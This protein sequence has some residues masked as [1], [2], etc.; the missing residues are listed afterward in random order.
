MYSSEKIKLINDWLG[1]GSINI[2]GRPFS[3]KDCQSRIL[4]DLL[5]GNM[6]G[7]GEI[8][9]GD[10]MPESVKQCMLLGTLVDTN[11][12]TE[13]ILHRLSQP[14][15][16][17]KPLILNSIGRSHGEEEIVI[18]AAKNSKH[19]TKAVI[20]LTLS[21]NDIYKRLQKL[22]EVNDRNN[23]IDDSKELIA[24]RINEFRQKTK[25]VI[26]Y[27]KNIGLLYEIDGRNSIEQVT[28]DILDCLFKIATI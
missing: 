21:D 26:N 17:N 11:D 27:Y 14:K 15:F 7:A 5:D 20:Y 3:G 16:A 4:T 1:S 19:P 9:R 8:F 23:R 24:T 12:F 2:F 18:E 10:D 13:L 22:N 6:L 25:P 28:S